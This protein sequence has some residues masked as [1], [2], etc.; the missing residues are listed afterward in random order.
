MEDSVNVQDVPNSVLDIVRMF[1]AANNRGEHAVLIL[2]TKNQ[3]LKTKYRT[4]E[5][6]AGAPATVNTPASQG[7]KRKVNPARA[8][9]SRL[10]LEQFQNRKEEEK[11]KKQQ[12]TG[13]ETVGDA[14]RN[15]SNLIVKLSK[16]DKKTVLE[17]GPHGP[18]LQV[19]GQSL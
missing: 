10:R 9:R 4:V 5:K 3:Q 18:I 6:V 16:E 12:E 1:L 2:E 15:P 7:D 8:R 13:I 14:S 17:T 11:L 19:D